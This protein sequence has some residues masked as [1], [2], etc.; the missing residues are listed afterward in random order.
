MINIMTVTKVLNL[1]KKSDSKKEKLNILKTYADQI[2]NVS[3]N[4]DLFILGE[5]FG[6]KLY[7]GINDN[8]DDLK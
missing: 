3:L 7:L 4:A 5:I 1:L 2:K 6:V 8:K